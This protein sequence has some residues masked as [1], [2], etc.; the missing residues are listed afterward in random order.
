[1]KSKHLANIFIGHSTA[2]AAVLIVLG[3]MLG[4]SE[5]NASEEKPAKI[6]PGSYLGTWTG[7]DGSTLTLRNDMSGDYKSGGKTVNGAAVE[8]DEEAKEIR[9][10]FMGFGSGTYKID[11]PPAGNKMKLDGM[12]YTREE[13]SGTS[14]AESSSDE[15]V[16]TNAELRPVVV[17]T[18]NSFD[19]AVQTADFTKFRLETSEM[20]QDQMT[21]S[22]LNKAFKSLM[23][24][25]MSF[26]PKDAEAIAFSPKPTF[27]DKITLK[28]EVAYKPVKG[29]DVN[30]RLRYVNENGDWKLLGIRLNP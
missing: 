11:R 3:L 19:E 21:A 4:C 7:Q 17:A 2:A 23:K 9:F 8:V 28:V 1:M 29:P 15:E 24:Q 6:I 20:W 25:K 13:S 5:S 10:S 18:L 12:E 22:E 26:V 27:E 30:F 14:T 16:P